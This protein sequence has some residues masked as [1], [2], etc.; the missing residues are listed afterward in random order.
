MISAALV[1]RT[2]SA[3]PLSIGTSLA[4]ESIFEGT[5][6]PYDVDRV[7]PNKV[8]ITDYNYFFINISTLVRNVLGAVSKSS[9]LSTEPYGVAEVL[10]NEID[11]IN[12]IMENDAGGRCKVVYYNNTYSKIKHTKNPLILLRKDNTAAQQIFT[13]KVDKSIHIFVKENKDIPVIEYRDYP[14]GSISNTALILTHVPYDLLGF[15]T[16]SKLDLIESHTGKLKPKKLW[17][18]KLY[19][20]SG[21][22]LSY[23]P[24]YKWSLV[25]FGDHVMF[26]PHSTKVRLSILD[27]AKKGKWTS[28]TPP[29]KVRHDL[30][31]Y[32]RD[33]PLRNGILDI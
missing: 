30:M 6:S 13:D 23:I 21:E 20:M 15:R 19:K 16:F 11:I 17:Y 22:D 29:D 3:F 7:I 25:F 33:I 32:M 26:H 14:T 18:T 28:S 4:F 10:R 8:D 27:V 1:S 24:F 2:T 9:Y 5:Y 12:S 31:L